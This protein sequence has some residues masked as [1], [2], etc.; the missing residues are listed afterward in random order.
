MQA[1]STRLYKG[2]SRQLSTWED[3]KGSRPLPVR[4]VLY[5][6]KR[7][8]RS[9]CPC[10]VVNHCNINVVRILDPEYQQP[11]VSLDS[12]FLLANESIPL[13]I[14]KYDLARE[15]GDFD[16]S[17]AGLEPREALWVPL[18]I[19][20]RVAEELGIL[21]PLSTLLDWH[22]RH[23]WTLD[24]GEDG[25]IHN[26]RALRLD[27]ATYS[28]ATLVETS[29]DNISLLPKGQQV[30][31]FISAELRQESQDRPVNIQV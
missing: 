23:A 14:L 12:I 16:L 30:R 25:F 22:T 4:F 15:A 7:T 29:I 31:T 24:E 11:Y 28:M 2:T 17:L 21:R 3:L 10:L 27:A 13:G 20:R 19:A 26:W 5:A 1:D 18:K 9:L 6:S 8:N